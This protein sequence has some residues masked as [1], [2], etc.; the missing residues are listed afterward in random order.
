MLVIFFINISL[1]IVQIHTHSSTNSLHDHVTPDILPTRYDGLL[2]DDD[3]F[4]EE[5]EQRIFTREDFYEQ[6]AEY[7]IILRNNYSKQLKMLNFL[8]RIISDGFKNL[9]QIQVLEILTTLITLKSHFPYR[10]W[11]NKYRIVPSTCNSVF[12]TYF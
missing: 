6:F 5:F 3:A 2:S 8:F 9:D 12:L 4:D 7:V 11:D 10:S 1:F